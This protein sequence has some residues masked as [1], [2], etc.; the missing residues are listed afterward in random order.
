MAGPGAQSAIS[1]NQNTVTELINNPKNPNTGIMNI[2]VVQGYNTAAAGPGTNNKK[3]STDRGHVSGEAACPQGHPT[4]FRYVVTAKEAAN[5]TVAELAQECARRALLEREKGVNYQTCVVATPNLKS[6]TESNFDK[7]GLRISEATVG[8]LR[9]ANVCRASTRSLVTVLQSASTSA[10]FYPPNPDGSCRTDEHRDVCL[11]SNDTMVRIR[12]EDYNPALHYPPDSDGRCRTGGHRDVCLRSNDTMVR[13]RAEDFNSALHYDPPCGANIT[14]CLRSSDTQVTIRSKDF[15]SALHYN[16]VNNKCS[17]NG[18]SSG[19]NDGSSS[20]RNDGSSSGRNDGSDP[21]SDSAPDNSNDT[22]IPYYEWP[23]YAIDPSTGRPYTVTV[24][25]S[26]TVP[27]NY[28]ANGKKTTLSY[29]VDVLCGSATN[30]VS[31]ESAG[32][33]VSGITLIMNQGSTNPSMRPCASLVASACGYYAP[34]D[35][36]P[37]TGQTGTFDLYF[38]TP[39]HASG[40]ARTTIALSSITIERELNFPDAS[41]VIVAVDNYAA[42]YTVNGKS[43][44]PVID[45][46]ILG[47]FGGV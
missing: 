27:E 33:K 10:D 30:R 3:N 14:V 37:L 39:M 7:P 42:E 16:L 23:E 32:V 20:G 26:V 40:Y 29:K 8:E 17:S 36:K 35:E 19:R 15:N 21:D 46:K 43:S 47:S 12:A 9:T 34:Q 22:G 5:R 31:C 11:W 28:V 4:C 44:S 38:Y 13:I 45:R 1:R 2:I 25:V 24:R 41:P 6:S 18:S